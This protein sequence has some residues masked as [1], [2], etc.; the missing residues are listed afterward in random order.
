MKI[1]ELVLPFK[2]RGLEEKTKSIPIH[3]QQ[4]II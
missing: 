1:Y 4:S 2:P 3:W